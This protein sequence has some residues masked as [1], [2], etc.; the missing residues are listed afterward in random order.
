MDL[1]H[2][3]LSFAMHHLIGR[4]W[5]TAREPATRKKGRPEKISTLTIPFATVIRTIEQGKME[6]LNR[7]LLALERA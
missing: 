4:G 6:D 1:S 5:V 2:P 7:M 3:D